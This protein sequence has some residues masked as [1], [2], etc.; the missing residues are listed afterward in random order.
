VT[1]NPTSRQDLEDLLNEPEYFQATF[2][3][4]PRVKHILQSQ[5]ELGRANEAI[6]SKVHIFTSPFYI[7]RSPCIEKT[8]ASQDHVYKLRGE[9]QQAFDQAKALEVKA[10]QLERKQQELHQVFTCSYFFRPVP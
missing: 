7:L 9:T 5:V 4:L 1:R 10:K 3:S 8:L 2:L 6:A